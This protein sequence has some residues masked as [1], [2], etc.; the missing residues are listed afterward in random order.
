MSNLE[1]ARL[2]WLEERPQHQEFAS[3]LESRLRDLLSTLG[4]WF[5]VEVRAKEVDSLIKKLMRGHH[6]YESLPDKVGVRVILR[7]RKDVPKIVEEI[8][9]AFHCG[10]F[11]IKSPALDQVGYHSTHIDWVRLKD[12]DPE[13]GRFVPMR[14]WA[15]LQVR[16]QS[17]HLWSEMS[18]SGFYKNDE[19][20]SAISDDAKRRVNLMAGQL[21]VADREFDRLNG[22]RPKT[23]EAEIF[24]A[25]E[26]FYYQLSTRM[27]DTQ[28]SLDVIRL[29]TPL[30]NETTPTV[31]SLI[32]SFFRERRSFLVERYRQVQETSDG[33][34]SPLFFQPEA[35]LIYERLLNDELSLRRA[36]NAVFPEQLL[37]EF[38]NE[39]GVAFD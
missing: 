37:E 39:M 22:E 34:V 38:A 3:I 6:S 1:E 4:V 25:L 17:Q 30:Y 21:E 12:N 8:T 23:P 19:T 11:D 20:L 7:Y 28:L 10:A 18:H 29:L 16:T 14:F 13:A 33:N 9:K 26:P 36:W 32:A 27:P 2:Q 15:E 5:S 35:L 24:R 31:E